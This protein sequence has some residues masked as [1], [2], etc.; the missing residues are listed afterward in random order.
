M[1]RL[2]IWVLFGT[3]LLAQPRDGVTFYKDV[4]PVLQRQCQSCHRPGEIA[5][6]SFLT[7]PET[8]PWAAAIK[9]AVITK[10]MPPWFADPN[11]GHFRNERRLSA[12]ELQTL[13]KW[14]DS[15]ATEG[16]P[17]DKPAPVRFAE[18]WSIGKPDLVV[19]FP[20]AIQIPA[21]GLMDQSNLVVK[22]NFPRD[23]W[24][25]A[26][27][28]RP[29]NAK[30]VHHMKAWIRPPGSAWLKDA[31]EGE[32]YVPKRGAGMGAGAPTPQAESTGPRPAQEILAKYNPGVNAQEFTVGDAAKFIAAGSDIV[33]ECHYTTTGK[34]ET[35]LTKV[36]I[37]FATKA[38]KQRY[39]TLTAINN[40]RFVIPAR[41]PNHEV[42]AESILQS[43]AKIAWVQPH[44]HYRA[45]DYELRA[46]YPSG[47][48]EILMKAKFD[49]NWQLGYE[50]EKPVLLPKGT[51]LEMTAHYDNTENNPF[52]PNPNIDVAYGPQSTDEMAVSFIG[53][54]IDVNGD[55]MKLFPRRGSG[56]V[57]DIQ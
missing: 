23:A 3:I 45:R 16:D 25:Q 14:A 5:P 24:I 49:F 2:T 34:P 31:P 51:R 9:K 56:A 39:V 42:K 4:L 57:Q 6:M 7:Y 48:S 33:F 43:D 8:R 46:F 13:V 29:G 37:V 53:F 26:A 18:G 1:V 47:E 40:Q 21:T 50:F 27:E 54:V 52:N 35:D 11:Y 17:K 19:Q 30:V 32:L 28:I 41:A 38:P 20:R 10:K 44:M 12:A 36:A 22:V 15:G 55:P